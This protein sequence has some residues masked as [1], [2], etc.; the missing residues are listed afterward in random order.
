MVLTCITKVLISMAKQAA[1]FRGTELMPVSQPAKAECLSPASALRTTA[2]CLEAVPSTYLLQDPWLL[3]LVNAL[4]GMILD[5]L[6][7]TPLVDCGVFALANFLINAAIQS[8]FVQLPKVNQQ[9]FETAILPPN[10]QHC[11]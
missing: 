3:A 11:L 9:H 8:G 4:D 7:L 10:Q 1:M 6:L 2:A 5:S